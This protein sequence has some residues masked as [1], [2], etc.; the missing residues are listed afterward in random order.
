MRDTRLRPLVFRSLAR[1][2]SVFLAVA[3]VLTGFQVMLVVVA[4]ALQTSRSFSLMS[5]L[6]PM[7]VQ[8]AF[9]PAALMLASFAGLATFGY[10]HPI[11]VL[12]IILVGVYVATEPAGEIEWGLFDLELTR[13]VPRRAVIT[14]S[15]LVA[16]GVTTATACAMIAGT[17]AG[18]AIF[19]PPGADW[20]HGARILDLAA[21]LVL[22]S[23]PFAA[24]G[25]VASAVARRRGAAFGAVAVA[26]ACLY[27]MNF[28]ADAWAP[29]APL[30]PYLPFHYFSG[31]AVASGTA[32]TAHDLGVL[33]AAAAVLVGLA[34]WRFERR[35]L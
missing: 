24:A 17:F 5:A 25:L 4:S 3:V 34:Y 23:W 13:P 6:M 35:D 31:L 27:L 8:Q 2:R 18:L 1:G 19:A 14:R 11:V 7:G 33:A 21:H 20:P 29:A 26:V 10:F 22:L 15:L 30:R 16:F 32:P 9:G 12:A 28:V